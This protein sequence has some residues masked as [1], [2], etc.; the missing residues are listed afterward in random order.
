MSKE[1]LSFKE[2]FESKQKLKSAGDNCPRYFS[3]YEVN[4]Y[5]KIPLSENPNEDER[6]Y[7]ALKPKDKIKIL[8]E[9]LDFEN[10]IPKH[11]TVID[12]DLEETKYHFT[13]NLPKINKW[14]SSTTHKK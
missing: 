13:W 1:K 7:I 5:C 4:K 2:Y 14:L 11:I 9:L 10:P 6:V 8:W 3:L 12:E